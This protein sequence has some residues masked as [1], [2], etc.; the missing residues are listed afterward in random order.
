[1]PSLSDRILTNSK[2]EATL[3][4]LPPAA[5]S[6]LEQN[7]LNEGSFLSPLLFHLSE[8]GEE[9]LVDGHHRLQVWDK[10]CENPLLEAPSYKDVAEL[11]GATEDT[12]VQWIRDHQKGRR[13]D[14]TLAEQYEVGK[15]FLNERESGTSSFEYAADNDMTPSQVRHT[16]SLATKIDEADEASPG[17]KDQILGDEKQTAKSA[18][19]AAAVNLDESPPSPLMV[20]SAIQKTLDRLSRAVGQADAAFPDNDASVVIEKIRQL[21]VDIR[22]WED[23][24]SETV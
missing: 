8:A 14:P 11:S 12:V 6:Q 16:A 10:H 13:N 7:I 22:A 5:F 21:G 2:Y 9:V 19:R 18:I 15:D 17:F 1:M 3:S 4:P 23:K 24:C 20:F